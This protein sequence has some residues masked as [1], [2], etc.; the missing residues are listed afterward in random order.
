MPDPAKPAKEPAEIASIEQLYLTGLHLEQ[1]RHATY[2]PADYYLEALAREPDDIRNNNAMGLWLMRRGQFVKAESHFRAAIAT[3]TDRNPNP[4]DGEPFF[5]LG[6]CLK[7]QYRYKDARD[8]FYKSVW[9]A[10]WQDAGYFNLAQLAAMEGDWEE[11]LDLV[12]RSLIRNWHNHKARHL[13]IAIMRHLNRK[14]EALKSADDSLKIDGFNFGIL[15]EKHLLNGKLTSLSEMKKLMRDNVHNYI[16]FSLDYAAAGMLT[17]A[18]SFLETLLIDSPE[19][20]PMICYFMGWFNWQAGDSSGATRFFIKAEK[21]DPA[22]C[23]P[24]RLEEILALQC[25]IKL[26]PGG[27]KAPYYLG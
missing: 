14:E 10:A 21:Q 22:F 15:F 27:S 19:T 2:N 7:F 26:N 25:A 16:E 5:N 23:F 18:K 1:Y 17:E 4:Y 9:N 24:N 6:L 3:L 20:Y 11:S 8:A 12:S 13:K